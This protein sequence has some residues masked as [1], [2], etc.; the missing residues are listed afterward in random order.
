MLITHAE[1]TASALTSKLMVSLNT[2][3]NALVLILV[4]SARY[5]VDSVLVARVAMEASV[6]V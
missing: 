6:S 2:V 5:S 4:H 1:I 3:A